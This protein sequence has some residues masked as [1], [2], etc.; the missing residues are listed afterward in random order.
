M[1]SRSEAAHPGAPGRRR[2]IGFLNHSKRSAGHNSIVRKF[3]V[4]TPQSRIA[5]LAGLFI[6]V[7]GNLE[8]FERL[9]EVYPLTGANLPFLSSLTLFFTLSTVLFLVLLTP[10]RAG[11]WVLATLLVAAS[12]AAYFMDQY[13]VVIDTVMIENIAATQREE[14]AGLFS[15]S[16]IWRTVLF[17]VLPAWWVVRNWPRTTSIWRELGARALLSLLLLVGLVAV[18]APFTSGYASFIREHKTTRMY[19]NPIF[20]SYSLVRYVGEHFEQRDTGVLG[21]VAED[22]QHIGPQH[23]PELV[24]LVVGETARADRFSLN[25][26]GRPTNPRLAQEDVVSLRNVTACGTSTAESVP[27]M[28][29]VQKQEHFNRGEA[30]RTENALDVLFENGV[31]VLWRDNNSDSKGVATRMTYED[32]RSPK[33]NPAC[34]DECRDV[35]MLDGLDRYIE[36]HKGRDMLIVLHQMGNHGPE[37]YRRYPKEFERFTPVCRSK[38]LRDCSK[39]EIDNAYDNAILYTDHFLAEV[40]GLLKRYDGEYETAMLYVSDHGESLGES[41]LYLHSA[42]RMLAPE[43]QL[44]VPAIV[45][46]G[47]HFDYTMEQLRP[48]RDTP[49]RHDDLFCVLM[50]A[51]EI[52]T[53][54]CDGPKN[55]LYYNRELGLEPVPA[56]QP[57]S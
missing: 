6:M 24:V 49:M 8:L 26:Y 30:L 22:A 17:G 5:A 16:L 38:E 51:F 53:R 23:R 25:G 37:Y 43:E 1:R 52:R 9:G 48:H 46:L 29:S 18:A 7:T 2:F 15:F 44:R 32:F 11:R 20:F 55:I 31:H 36:S 12:Q 4:L 42:P 34:D 47:R 33:R 27:C 57:A 21:Q 39:Q 45:W 35:G 19:A 14:V 13:A 56:T 10:G 28:F 3:S 40:I 54:M 50:S 41:G